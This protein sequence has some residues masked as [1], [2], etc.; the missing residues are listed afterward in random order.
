MGIKDEVKRQGVKLMG[1]PRV[2]KAMQ[3]EQF[4]RAVSAIFELTGKVNTFTA[5]QSERFAKALR[6]ATAE[7]LGDLE[8]RVRDLE[9]EL[10]RVRRR[11]EERDS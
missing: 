11:L 5:E 9:S 3:N 1:D 2:A 6:L 4:L 10:G 7:E 8:R